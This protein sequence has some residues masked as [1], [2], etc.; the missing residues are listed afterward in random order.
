MI[1]LAGVLAVYGI[2]FTINYIIDRLRKIYTPNIIIILGITMTII[3]TALLGGII[4][5]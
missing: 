1:V 2:F 3:G 4:L 5:K